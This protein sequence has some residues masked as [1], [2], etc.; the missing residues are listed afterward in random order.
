MG[1]K[2]KFKYEDIAVSH[3]KVTTQKQREVIPSEPFGTI[4]KDTIK[5]PVTV[6]GLC[7]FLIAIL[8]WG[9]VYI[10]DMVCYDRP[11]MDVIYEIESIEESGNYTTVYWNQGSHVDIPDEM[12][13]EGVEVGDTLWAYYKLNGNGGYKVTEVIKR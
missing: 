12:M 2:H 11:A 5:A 10:R 6:L 13:P 3:K 1:K 8:S 4:L 9:S 7:A